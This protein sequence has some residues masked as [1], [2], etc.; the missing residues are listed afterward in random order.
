M[1]NA[2]CGKCATGKMR[3][4]S[5]RI[6]RILHVRDFPQS[7]FYRCP[8]CTTTT[9]LP[10]LCFACFPIIL[11]KWCHVWATNWGVIS[12]QTSSNQ[13]YSCSV[14]TSND[15]WR[16]CRKNIASA[17]SVPVTSANSLHRRSHSAADGKLASSSSLVS[18]MFIL[19]ILVYQYLKQKYIIKHTQRASGAT[20]LHS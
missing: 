13:H 1:W 11:N 5:A 14:P 4:H 16:S 6:F 10:L 19:K 8:C 2:D 9:V 17:V 20:H 18:L 7:A 12:S 3:I 15:H